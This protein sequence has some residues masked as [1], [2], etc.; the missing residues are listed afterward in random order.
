MAMGFEEEFASIPGMDAAQPVILDL[1]AAQKPK[2]GRPAGLR[3][4]AG[5]TCHNSRPDPRRD[6]VREELEEGFTELP[7]DDVPEEGE[8]EICNK[9]KP[10]HR[11]VC[12]LWSTGMYTQQQIAEVVGYTPSNIGLILRSR[13]GRAFTAYLGGKIDGTVEDVT[14][15]INRSA[16]VAMKRVYD[17]LTDENAAGTKL[18][19]QTAWDILD[20]AGMKAAQNVNINLSDGLTEA[21]FARLNQADDFK[22]AMKEA[23]VPLDTLALLELSDGQSE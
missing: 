11:Q 10:R 22:K 18:Q 8:P 5:D 4:S 2:R 19:M 7:E 6:K 17:M 23:D 14:F 21:D 3:K 15:M 9:L 1:D 16:S 12:R 20:R 13:E